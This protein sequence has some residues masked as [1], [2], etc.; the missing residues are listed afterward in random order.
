MKT[1]FSLFTKI[2]LWFLFSFAVIGAAA[3]AL[4]RLQARLDPELPFSGK[5]ADRIRASVKLIA[6]EL[7]QTSNEEWDAVLA[8]WSEAYQVE[9]A[10][11]N[12]DGDKIAGA[13]LKPPEDVKIM[14]N[15]RGRFVVKTAMPRR[16]WIG[17]P[18]A[19]AFSRSTEERTRGFGSRMRKAN[20]RSRFRDHV[21][22]VSSDPSTGAG[23]FTD[24]FPWLTVSVV[25]VLLS[26]LL[27]LPLVRNLTRPIGQMTGAAEQIAQGRFDTRVS[28]NRSDEIGRLGKAINDMAAKLSRLVEGQKRFLGDV[29]H[30]LRSP[31]TRISIALELLDQN[32]DPA[33]QK[34]IR[35]GL[36]EVR[37]MN[38]LVGEL[39]A[40]ARE[41]T[42]PGKANLQT[43]KLATLLVQVIDRE[44]D[45]RANL[46]LEV[47]ETLEAMAD[48]ELLSRAAANLVR[49]ALR[50]A[51]DDGPIQIRAQRQGADVEIVFADSGPGVPP[52][53]IDQIF[54]PFFR[55]EPDRDRHTGGAGLGLSIVKT[56]VEACGG[57]VGAKNLSPSGFAVT[58]RLKAV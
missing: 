29:S 32:A 9:F 8:R 33:Q 50:Y 49:N 3:I 21:L 25:V 14:L 18:I 41:Q 58:I 57:D 24:T 55:L 31:L 20:L 23:F 30:E 11:Y 34:Y 35:D 45:D 10:L 54:D 44:T 38:D 22:V 6:D 19:H 48:P 39:M 56:C 26:I 42:E 13:D 27:W 36:E 46:R 37:Q 4:I 17:V 47:P 5:S 40:V 53:F 12:R 15:Q 28:E 7:V 2:V 1:R 43:V 51:A 16:F 52:Q